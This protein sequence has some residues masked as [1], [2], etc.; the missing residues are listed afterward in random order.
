MGS[1]SLR[2]AFTGCDGQTGRETTKYNATVW[3]L[4]TVN[5]DFFLTTYK[6]MLETPKS[7]KSCVLVSHFDI[8]SH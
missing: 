6:F 8:W 1:I 2:L 5:Y 7:L 4:A 3:S